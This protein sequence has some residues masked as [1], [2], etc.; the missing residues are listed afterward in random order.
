LSQFRGNTAPKPAAHRAFEVG[1]SFF[2][3]ADMSGPFENERLLGQAVGD[4]RDQVVI[5]TKFGNMRGDDGAF[6]GVN[7]M[8]S[9]ELD[10][11]GE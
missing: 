9:Y 6:L 11:Y 2:D 4:R 1:V 10:L 5:A 3:T 7:G 8:T